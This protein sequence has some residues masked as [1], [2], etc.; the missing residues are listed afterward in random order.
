VNAAEGARVCAV[1]SALAGAACG[2]PEVPSAACSEWR[3][4][5]A[6]DTLAARLVA[7]VNARRAGAKRAPL[8]VD[9]RIDRVARAH[10][11]AMAASGRLFH[12]S[13]RGQSADGRLRSAG[14]TDW[15]VVA[16]NLALG[17]AVRARARGRGGGEATFCHDAES[18]AADV[19]DGWRKS[20]GHRRNLTSPE[21][22]HVGTGAAY[23]A[24]KDRVYVVQVYVRR[25]AAPALRGCA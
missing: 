24:G 25:R 5:A 11:S 4:A 3:D 8:S 10:A 13:P 22:T 20:R 6:V 18:L 12:R 14:I 2:D 1:A 21:L 16:E 23:D 7:H 15:D 19:V 17:S 9:P